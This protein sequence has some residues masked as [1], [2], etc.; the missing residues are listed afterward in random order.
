MDATQM[1]DGRFVALKKTSKTK[2]SRELDI[3]QWFASEGANDSRNHCVPVLRV[4]DV[5]DHDDLVII[6]MPLLRRFDSPWF[7]TIGEA[8]ECIKQLFEVPS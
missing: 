5:P 2:N 8:V 7:N 6:V 3:L 1:S 4:L